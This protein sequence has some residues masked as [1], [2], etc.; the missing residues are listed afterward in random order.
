MPTTEA[1][2]SHSH[3]WSRRAFVGA[4]AALAFGQRSGAALGGQR[5]TAR[6]IDVHHHFLPK[7]YVDFLGRHGLSYGFGSW[8]VQAD[9]DDMNASGTATAILSITN[10]GF[11]EGHIE[12]SRQAARAANEAAARLRADHPGRFGSFAALPLTD[13][14]GALHEIQYALDTLKADG[15]GLFS[16]YADKWLGHASFAPVYEELNRRK[17]IVYVHPTFPAC[18]SNIRNQTRIPNEAALLEFGF[19]TTRA[20][21]DLVFSGTTTRYPDVVW[22][23]SHAGGTMPFLIERFLTGASAQ[24]VPGV[25]TKGQSFAPPGQVPGGVLAELRKMY[26]DTAQSSNPV[27]MGALRTVVPVSQ[28]LFGTDVWYRTTAE[29]VRNLTTCGVFNTTEL[30]AIGRGNAERIM[31]RYRSQSV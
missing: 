5:D 17:T 28:I 6:R 20:I 3:T 16:S 12:D 14:D 19:D 4:A 10:P 22:I 1:D 8:S 26:Y 25:L 18:C 31:P 13:T 7:S 29:E 21:A 9:L 27:A 11:G 2:D 15:I 23:F 30:Q 24:I